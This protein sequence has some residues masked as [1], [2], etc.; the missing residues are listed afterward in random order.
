MSSK[1]RIRKNE[2]K[3]FYLNLTDDKRQTHGNRFPKDKTPLRVITGGKKYKA[4]KRGNTRIGG[5]LNY[6]YEGE[7]GEAGD[8][9][10]VRFDPL[11]KEIEGR[12]P[13]KIEIINRRQ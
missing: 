6:W 8:K 5:E 12:I 11:S 9:I 4:S 3:T 10:R 7:R 2:K 13:V 1:K